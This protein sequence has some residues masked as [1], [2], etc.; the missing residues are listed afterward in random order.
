[1][2]QKN[3]TKFEFLTICRLYVSQQQLKIEAYKQRTYLFN[4]PCTSYAREKA[5]PNAN[6]G[7]VSVL[8]NKNVFV[9]VFFLIL[10]GAPAMSLT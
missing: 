3:S 9:F 1:M 8:L 2:G 4:R 10:Y 7:F 6:G 5:M